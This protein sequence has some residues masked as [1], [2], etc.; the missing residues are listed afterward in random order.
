MVLVISLTSCKKDRSD[1]PSVNGTWELTKITGGFGP[2][3]VVPTEKRD[4]YEFILNSRYAKTDTNKV[5]TEGKFSIKFIDENNGYRFG[6]ITF[7][8]PD[9]SDAISF[10]ADTMLLGSSAADGPT[11]QYIR[12]K[13]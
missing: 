1:I 6:T 13:K 9:Y 10:K 7:T 11:Y 12:I 5:V 3:M 2:G 4:R 8:N